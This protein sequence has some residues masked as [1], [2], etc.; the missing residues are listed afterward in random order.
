MP[1]VCQLTIGSNLSI[2]IM[3]YKSV[4][5]RFIFFKEMLPDRQICLDKELTIH[6]WV[7]QYHDYC[8]S[9]CS[10]CS[11]HFCLAFMKKAY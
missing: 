3:A 8:F 7:I 4:S 11:F 5:G 6:V 2:K 10:P 1:W 9:K